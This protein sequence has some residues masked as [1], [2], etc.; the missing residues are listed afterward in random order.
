[1]TETLLSHLAAARIHPAFVGPDQAALE[2][3]MAEITEAAIA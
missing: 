3:M 2:Q 1:M